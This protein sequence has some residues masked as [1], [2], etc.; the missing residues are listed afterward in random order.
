MILHR[1]FQEYKVNYSRTIKD[2]RGAKRNNRLFY[3]GQQVDQCGTGRNNRRC[4]T[5]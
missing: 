3:L 4:W 2:Q 1:T 5:E